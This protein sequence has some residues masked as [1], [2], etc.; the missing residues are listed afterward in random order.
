MNRADLQNLAELR[1]TEAKILLDE[2]SFPGAFYLAG[3]AIECALKACIAKE[4]KQYDFPD[5][6]QVNKIYSHDLE[7]L[8]SLA[9]LEGKLDDDMRSNGDLRAYWN[10][11]VDWNE[12]KRYELDFKEAET[13]DLYRAIADPENGVLQWLKKLW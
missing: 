4:T 12:E 1:I 13:R 5:K 9:K 6:K 8:L 2:R 11:V 3:Y 7:E 10:S